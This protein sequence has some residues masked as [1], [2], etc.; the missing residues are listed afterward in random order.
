MGGPA[1]I[2]VDHFSTFRIGGAGVA[3]LRLSAALRRQGVDSRFV[4]LDAPDDSEG[5]F[6]RLPQ[7]YP[8]LHQRVLDRLGISSTEQSRA[9][10]KLAALGVHGSPFTFPY[11]DHDLVSASSG[12]RV[13]MLHLHWVAGVMD[14]PSFFRTCDT[15]VVWTLHDM[16]PFLG[17]LHYTCDEA[18][19]SVEARKHE[20]A[21]RAAKVK[22]LEGFSR[23]IC[24]SPSQWLRDHAEASDVLGRFR[25]E[26]I[27]NGVDVSRFRPHPQAFARA[28]LDLPRDPRLMLIVAEDLASYRKGGDLFIEAVQQ[29]CLPPEWSVVSAGRGSLSLDAT[30][31]HPVGS[32]TDERLMALLYS[33]VDLVVVP[34]RQDN[35]PNVLVEAACC[36][37]AAVATD[38]GGNGEVVRDG[39]NGV[40][41]EAADAPALAAALRRA[42]G[43]TFET[44]AI[45]RDAA[46]RFDASLAARRYRALYEDIRRDTGAMRTA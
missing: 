4:A 46:D 29:A 26:V 28:V 36:G 38:V 27:P 6:G 34:S 24:V 33:A 10:R 41:A 7:H 11:S 16:N 13:D 44:E 22:A 42:I 45:R 9:R 30:P 8:R 32:I 3:G 23:L 5:G 12:R 35:L 15:P 39:F 20:K 40:L 21:L 2:R 37:T 18:G 17:G 25:H 14:W 1:G 43:T 31:V 19:L